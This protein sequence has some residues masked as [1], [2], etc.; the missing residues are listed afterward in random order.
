MSLPRRGR[1][2]SRGFVAADPDRARNLGRPH[3]RTPI[4]RRLHADRGDNP[5][6]A[7]CATSKRLLTSDA[8]LD[9]EP[10]LIVEKTRS[11]SFLQILPCGAAS[12]REEIGLGAMALILATIGTARMPPF[13]IAVALVPTVAVGNLVAAVL[14]QRAMQVIGC[15]DDDADTLAGFFARRIGANPGTSFGFSIAQFKA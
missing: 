4:M 15:N 11:G 12:P 10:N 2:H 3:P 5:F 14:I 6:P 1:G 7:N 9:N 8:R 13:S